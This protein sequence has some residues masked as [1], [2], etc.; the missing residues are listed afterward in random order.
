MVVTLFLRWALLQ[1][2]VFVG[3][4]TL[5]LLYQGHLHDAGKVMVG[6]VLLVYVAASAYCG[7][8]AWLGGRGPLRA[9][10]SPRQLAHV[11][12][13]ITVCPMLALI[14]T[15]SGF[16]I[17]FSGGVEDVQSRVL[18]AS[19]GL[20]ATFVGIACAVLLMVQRHALEE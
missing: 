4:V 3:F 10:P 13:S 19:T 18:G 14:G 15:V 6:M 17:A 11:S 16:L 5:L 2:L 7:R 9:Y 20:A 1:S 12:L 8:L